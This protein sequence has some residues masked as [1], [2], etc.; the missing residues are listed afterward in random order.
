MIVVS[1]LLPVGKNSQKTLCPSDPEKGGAMKNSKAVSLP[2]W[3]EKIGHQ[4]DGIAYYSDQVKI[5]KALTIAIE[6]L[7]FC[8]CFDPVDEYS[9]AVLRRIE[10]LGK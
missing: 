10:A 7:E 4:T 5:L 2:K 1:A 9:K 6:A 8:S 3:A